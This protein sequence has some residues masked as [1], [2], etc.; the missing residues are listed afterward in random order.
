[1]QAFQ[2]YKENLSKILLHKNT[3]N[4]HILQEKEYID[5]AG[6]EEFEIWGEDVQDLQNYEEWLKEQ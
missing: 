1:M 2:K 5:F 4:K 3:Q 6:F